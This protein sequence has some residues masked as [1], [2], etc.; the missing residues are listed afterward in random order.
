MHSWQRNLCLFALMFSRGLHYSYH[1]CH[2]IISCRNIPMQLS[3]V[4]SCVEVCK[5]ELRISKT[6][7]CCE[8]P[9]SGIAMWMV[10]FWEVVPCRDSKI[11]R[12]LLLPI[13]WDT[14]GNSSISDKSQ[15]LKF[16]AK[17][18]FP[19]FGPPL[20]LSSSSQEAGDWPTVTHPIL[21]LAQST[22]GVTFL[23]KLSLPAR[24]FV[25]NSVNFLHWLLWLSS[26]GFPC[27]QFIKV[28]TEIAICSH[29]SITAHLAS[30]FFPNCQV[31]LHSILKSYCLSSKAP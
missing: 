3:L 18:C 9:G 28:A 6:N 12:Q 15:T 13:L 14:E 29:F 22:R 11:Q 17:L 4:F 1:F 30:H 27:V 7:T 24:S 20:G 31:S 26:F 19:S 25:H 2:W 8:T 23:A 16:V 10:A 21:D 5:T